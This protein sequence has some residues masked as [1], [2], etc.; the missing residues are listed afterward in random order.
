VDVA[1]FS[2]LAVADDVDVAAVDE[3]ASPSS[4][5]AEAGFS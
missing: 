4:A 1:F 2:A 3:P 5:C